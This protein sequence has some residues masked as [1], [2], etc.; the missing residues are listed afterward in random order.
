MLT[1]YCMLWPCTSGLRV[2]Y[3]VPAVFAANC[4]K[5]HQHHLTIGFE[6]P[7]FHLLIQPSR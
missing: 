3:L 5:L 6:A 7:T 4:S 1:V 2:L